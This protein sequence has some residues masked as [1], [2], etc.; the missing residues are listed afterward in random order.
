MEKNIQLSPNPF[1]NYANLV[2]NPNV[3]VVNGKLNVYDMN[4]RVVKTM[5]TNDAHLITIYKENLQKGIYFY[6]FTSD[7]KLLG[8]GKFII[9]E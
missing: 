9:T 2:I 4:G 1:T 5:L 6:Q 3:N 7:D 8:N